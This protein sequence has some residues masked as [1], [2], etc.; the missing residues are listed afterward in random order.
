LRRLSR[1]FLIPFRLRLALCLAGFEDRTESEA[2]QT[3][4]RK[5]QQMGYRAFHIHSLRASISL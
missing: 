1:H 3:K 4:A 5:N 2:R